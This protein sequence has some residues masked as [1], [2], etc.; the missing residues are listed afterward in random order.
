[1]EY[2]NGDK[3]WCWEGKYHRVDGPAIECVDGYKAWYYHG[4]V[5]SHNDIH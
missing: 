2:S 4:Q 3:Y 1:V 5:C